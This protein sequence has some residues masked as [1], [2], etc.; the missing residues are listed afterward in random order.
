MAAPKVVNID[1]LADVAGHITA[2]GKER[3]V[4][5]LDGGAYRALYEL[6]AQGNA[7]VRPLYATVAR[8]VPSL[9]EKEIDRLTARQVG[10]ILA[11]AGHTV[12]EV[13]NAFPNGGGPETATTTSPA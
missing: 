8:I 4:L 10:A 2:F 6:E 7:D 13:E 9:T 12:T 1:L 11:V 3:E 5:Q